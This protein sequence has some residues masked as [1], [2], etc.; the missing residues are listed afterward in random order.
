MVILCRINSKEV[1]LEVGGI[2]ESGIWKGGNKENIRTRDV[3]YGKERY[4][5]GDPRRKEG[6]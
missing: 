2:S 6:I 1:K 4:K 3:I 5:W